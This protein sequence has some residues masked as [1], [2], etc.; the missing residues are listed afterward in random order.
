MPLAELADINAT[1]GPAMIR[2][3]NGLLTGYVYV[4]MA[5][6]DVGGYVEEAAA[7]LV[8]S[9][10]AAAGLRR[11]SGA[12]STRTCCACASGCARGA[13]SRSFLIL[14]LLYVNT[15]SLV[16]TR[17]RLLAVPFSAVGAVWFL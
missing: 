10:H 14:V 2:N 16:K 1:T 9:V 6:R 12:A 17:D 3:E 7:V 11:S 8:A 4:D 13:A 15:R 5:G